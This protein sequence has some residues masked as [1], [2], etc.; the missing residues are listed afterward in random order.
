MLT[1]S[2]KNLLT[3]LAV[4][5]LSALVGCGG[6]PSAIT[7]PNVTAITDNVSYRANIVGGSW[8]SI[9]GTNL[10]TNTRS[11]AASDFTDPAKLPTT[12]DGVSVRVNGV[13]AAICYISQTL[14][15]IQAPTPISGSVPVQVTVNGVTSNT[16]NATAVANAPAIF[17]YYAGTKVYPSAY[18]PDG[19]YVG[20]PAETVDREA[21]TVTAR[22]GKAFAYEADLGHQA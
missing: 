13:S 5:G 15:N 21:R 17:G 8:V 20:D 19:L 9:F 11:W 6:E 3:V 10:S 16:I 22:S 7:G 2:S 18:Y 4:T 12:L 1:L 14:I